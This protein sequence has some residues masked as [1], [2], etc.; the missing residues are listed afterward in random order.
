[1][2]TRPATPTISPALTAKL[3]PSSSAPRVMPGDEDLRATG[4]R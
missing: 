1:M 4:V 3:T 2:P